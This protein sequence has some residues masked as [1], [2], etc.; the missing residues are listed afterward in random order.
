M[1][2][3]NECWLQTPEVLRQEIAE[4]NAMLKQ[5]GG[6]LYT[7]IVRNEIAELQEILKDREQECA[8]T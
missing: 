3:V 4:R 7:S 5:L 8:G 2:P 6:W 1:R